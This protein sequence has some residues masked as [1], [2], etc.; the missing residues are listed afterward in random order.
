MKMLSGLKLIV[1]YNRIFGNTFFGWTDNDESINKGK[2]ILL[3]LWNVCLFFILSL[4]FLSMSFGLIDTN[5]DKMD[6]N[7][8]S[9][10]LPDKLDV[11]NLLYMVSGINFSGQ[12][13]ILAFY[14]ALIGRKIM[15]AFADEKIYFLDQSR[16]YKT[17]KLIIMCQICFAMVPMIGNLVSEFVFYPLSPLM[18]FISI[19]N[20]PSITIVTTVL[21]LIAYKS[22]TVRYE[23]DEMVSRKVYLV[24]IYKMLCSIERS[25]CKMDQYVSIYILFSLFSN[26]L[27][28]VSAICSFALN[29]QAKII[30]SMITLFFGL[31]NLSILCYIC[32]I[33]PA[34]L[35]N[36]INKVQQDLDV[37]NN[38]YDSENRQILIQIRE[39]NTRIGFTAFGFF[40]VNGNTFLTCLAQ[41]IS[42]SV[43]I[44]QTAS[45]DVTCNTP[46]I[47]NCT[48]SCFQN[49]SC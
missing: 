1:N 46:I 3:K 16:E 35:T 28:T 14:L 11:P 37:R 39:M 23:F 5:R 21:V 29:S 41:I 18:I 13:L 32:N 38:G 7:I 2:R 17:A 34:S 20:F 33:I 4:S 10:E 42:Y 19:M 6:K 12:T 31:S 40:R 26:T 43:I 45:Q 9:Q 36:M 44:I 22:L 24:V 30:E 47:Q 25:I 15:N 27:F 49:N 48:C 8:T